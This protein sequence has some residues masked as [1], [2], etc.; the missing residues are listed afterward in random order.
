MKTL[1]ESIRDAKMNESIKTPED[2]IDMI[3]ACLG[4]HDAL[5][6]I[7]AA[8]AK[9]DFEVEKFTEEYGEKILEKLDKALIACWHENF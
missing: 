5:K 3:V 7:C 6:D 4:N 2:A 8:A 9:G 1:T